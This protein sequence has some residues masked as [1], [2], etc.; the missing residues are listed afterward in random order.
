MNHWRVLICAIWLRIRG[1]RNIIQRLGFLLFFF[2]SF[3]CETMRYLQS[4]RY[5]NMKMWLYYWHISSELKCPN[6]FIFIGCKQGPFCRFLRSLEFVMRS[7]SR[8]KTFNLLLSL[9]KP[10]LTHTA[11]TDVSNSTCSECDQALHPCRF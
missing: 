2:F 9:K 7:I 8:D 10:E 1:K 11:K 4:K 5:K 6:I 3:A